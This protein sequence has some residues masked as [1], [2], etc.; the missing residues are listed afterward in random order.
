MTDKRICR[1]AGIGSSAIDNSAKDKFVKPLNLFKPGQ[2]G[3]SGEYQEALTPTSAK[4]ATLSRL[5]TCLQYTNSGAMKTVNPSPIASKTPTPL[6]KEFNALSQ[7]R[8]S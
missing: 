8:P 6:L 5:A 7:V 3:P 1:D 2:V 4:L